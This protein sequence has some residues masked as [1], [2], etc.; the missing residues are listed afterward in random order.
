MTRPTRTLLAPVLALVPVLLLWP[1]LRHALES[2]M[3]L[4]MLVEFPSLLAA[5]AC[6]A[7]L[8][9][10]RARGRRLAAWAAALDSRGWTGATWASIV[11][12]AWMIPSALD[13]ALLSG[14]VGAAKVASWWLAGAL[15][16]GSVRRMD[17][18]VL[19]FFV[20]N[21]AWM[22]ATAGL[23]YLDAPARLCV[24]YLQDDQRHAGIGLVLLAIGLG[25]LALRR[26]LLPSPAREGAGGEGAAELRAPG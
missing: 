1:A 8:A 12:L 10:R 23:L 26:V 22:A 9:E 14:A 17:P 21:L 11:A 24:A 16:A 15:L 25:A 2:R 5:G 7:R 4:H 20:G 6:A 18:E 19:L 13:A 3:S